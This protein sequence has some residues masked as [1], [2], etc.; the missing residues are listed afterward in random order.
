MP[1]H[2]HLDPGYVSSPQDPTRGWRLVW[3]KEP[4]YA[5]ADLERVLERHREYEELH[6][7]RPRGRRRWFRRRS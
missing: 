4:R 3:N 5:G 2:E 7:G 1:V 6:A